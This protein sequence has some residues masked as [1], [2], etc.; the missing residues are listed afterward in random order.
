MLDSLSFPWPPYRLSGVV[1]GCLL[2][3]GA[4]IAALGDA[5]H[6]PPYKAPPKAPVLFLKPRNTLALSGATIEVDETGG[7]LSI[8]ASLGI[9]IKATMT[10]VGQDTAASHIAGFTLVA[11]LSVPHDSYYRPS[12]RM[13]ARDG[14]CLIGPRVITYEDG[15]AAPDGLDVSVSLD[16]TS[17]QLAAPGGMVRSVTRLISD[18]SE[19]MTLDAGDIVL[20]GATTPLPIGR[21][22]QGFAIEAGAIGRLQGSLIVPHERHRA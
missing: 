6:K 7:N 14:S 22:G 16:G 15:L 18:I 10:R 19:F 12:V 20:L 5:V 8:G 11:D 3:D 13:K 21:A 1:Y 17:V 9:V 4:G 2:N